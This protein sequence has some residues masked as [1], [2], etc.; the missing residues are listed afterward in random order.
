MTALATWVGRWWDHLPPEAQAELNAVFRPQ[1]F[2]VAEPHEMSESALQ[3]RL[4]LTAAKE[5][6]ASLMRN[7]SGAALMVN[8]NRPDEEPRHVRFGLGNDSAA[9]NK[10]SKSSDLIGATPVRITAAHV[11][12]VLGVFTAVEVKTPGWTLRPSDARGAAQANFMNSV[13][14][15]GGFAGFAQSED[16]LRRI[17]AQGRPN[18]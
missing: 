3:G 14:V 2:I 16:D 7:N 4:R 5:F 13:A 8:P 11:G 9:L 15:L 10:K 18:M 1:D 6:G 12:K 17:M